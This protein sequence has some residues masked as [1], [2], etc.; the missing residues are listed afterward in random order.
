MKNWV[1]FGVGYILRWF[2]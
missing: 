2:S 1:D